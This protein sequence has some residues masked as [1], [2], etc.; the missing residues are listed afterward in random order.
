MEIVSEGDGK[1][2]SLALTGFNQW[3]ALKEDPGNLILHDPAFLFIFG[4]EIRK[5]KKD[6]HYRYL[7]IV[8]LVLEIVSVDDG[9][10]RFRALTGFNQ[11]RCEEWR[12]CGDLSERNP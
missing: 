2:R 8:C 6:E 5:S 7:S 4:K 3:R 11:W 9:R 10:R 1:R 12:D